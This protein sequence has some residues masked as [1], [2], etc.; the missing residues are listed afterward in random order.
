MPGGRLDHEDRRQIAT[1]LAEG[2]AYSDI[3]KRLRRPTST[4]TREV[5][6]NGGPHGY[7][8]DRA[9]RAT[10]QRARRRQPAVRPAPPVPDAYGRDPVAVRDFEEQFTSLM[11]QTGLPRMA[12]KV[13]GCLYAADTGSAT[14]AELVQRLQVSP[15]SVSLAI[16]YLEDQE[17]VRRDHKGR[18]EQY[19]IDDDV[20]FRAMLA[21]AK[22]NAVLADAAR[23]GGDTLGATTP[24][25]A[26]LHDMGQFLE[27]VGQDLIKSAEHW[28]EVFSARRTTDR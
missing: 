20:W 21:S 15:A 17:L 2:L 11:I 7:R 18:R 10:E 24:A 14:A 22:A 1:G 27:H 12:S 9:Q 28:R 23:R 19:L 25:G 5:I 16:R 13:L 8:P 3:A 26:R 4:I 6:R